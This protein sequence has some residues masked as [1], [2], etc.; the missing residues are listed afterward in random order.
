MEPYFQEYYDLLEG[1]FREMDTVLEGLSQEGLDWDP[2]VDINSVAVLAAH[3]SGS[4]RFWIAEMLRGEGSQRSRPDEFATQGVAAWALQEHLS[5]TLSLCRS[6][7][8]GLTL[9]DLATL[10][11]HPLDSNENRVSW[12]LAHALEHFARHL[13]QMEIT[14]QMWE[15]Q[16]I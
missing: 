15:M 7:L 9:A 4:T 12:C 2:G 16:D 1:L 5:E 3:A 11:T 10:R 13:G 8:A 6:A 14:R